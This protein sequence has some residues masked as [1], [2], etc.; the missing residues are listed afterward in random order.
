VFGALH[1]MYDES[2]SSEMNHDYSKSPDLKT[3]KGHRALVRKT[4]PQ[5]GVRYIGVGK[6][7]KL[8]IVSLGD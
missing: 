6:T 7:S 4:P 8:W 3:V 2:I 5:A 1:R